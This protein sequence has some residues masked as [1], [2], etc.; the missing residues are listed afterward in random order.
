MNVP[1]VENPAI[2]ELSISMGRKME[3]PCCGSHASLVYDKDDGF[4]IYCDNCCITTETDDDRE[5][6]IMTW[7]KR[8]KD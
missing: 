7:N 2:V 8:S 1:A 5:K 3:N 4:Q 6:L